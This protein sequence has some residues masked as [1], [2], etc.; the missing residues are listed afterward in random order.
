MLTTSPNTL[1]PNAHLWQTSLT[2]ASSQII[3]NNGESE[4]PCITLLEILHASDSVSPTI[5]HQS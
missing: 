2:I 3:N 1:I 5:N 4:Q